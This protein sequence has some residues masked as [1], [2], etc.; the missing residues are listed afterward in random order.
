MN[1]LVTAL[2]LAGLISL[3]AA[4]FNLSI[5]PRI[6]MGWLGVSLFALVAFLCQMG[7][8]MVK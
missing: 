5:T 6:S 1:M 8:V 3:A 4:A 7:M 2:M